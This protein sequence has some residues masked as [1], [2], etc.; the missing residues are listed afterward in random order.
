M[1]WNVG[2][3]NGARHG[4]LV[5]ARMRTHVRFCGR[6]VEGLAG[7]RVENEPLLQVVAVVHRVVPEQDIHQRRCSPRAD[8]AG[9][10]QRRPKR[11]LCHLSSPSESIHTEG[12]RG[13]Q[14]RNR[15]PHVLGQRAMQGHAHVCAPSPVLSRVCPFTFMKP[16][17][18]YSTSSMS[19][20]TDD[21]AA[22]A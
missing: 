12:Q 17:T 18:R 2:R 22:C 15:A 16:D 11:G 8:G 6:D 20:N 13:I 21:L 5:P 4:D 10:E 19:S 9:G 7:E 1:A 14:A 3:H